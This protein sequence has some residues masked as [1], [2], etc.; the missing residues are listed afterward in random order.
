MT[1]PS[2]RMIQYFRSYPTL[3]RRY[4]ELPRNVKLYIWIILGIAIV[5]TVL[6]LIL[7][8]QPPLQ[9]EHVFFFLVFSFLMELYSDS[10]SHKEAPS[11][12]FD[13]GIFFAGFSVVIFQNV[14]VLLMTVVLAQ[15][16][17]YSFGRRRV[18]VMT[19]NAAEMINGGLP[20]LWILVILGPVNTSDPI[21]VLLIS[22]VLAMV[23]N[24]IITFETRAVLALME[25]RRMLHTLTHDYEL[26]DE[27]FAVSIALIAFSVALAIPDFYYVL[28]LM[29]LIIILERAKAMREARE[30]DLTM[31]GH[32]DKIGNP[33]F[34]LDGYLRLMRVQL[35][36]EQFDRDALKE[37]LDGA[38]RENDSIKNE[39]KKSG[40]K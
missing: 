36:Q 19:F 14:W 10:I 1:S 39:I 31:R 24:I 8:D 23:F 13:I 33:L 25:K 5:L 3:G 9:W 4:G 34:S 38:I 18:H 35:E 12:L 17:S 40:D 32:L 6:T 27:V 26:G 21:L 28:F 22:F 16:A 7:V 29:L 20:L 37:T 30:V 15:I 11:Q 2:R